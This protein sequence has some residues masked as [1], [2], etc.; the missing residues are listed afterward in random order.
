MRQMISLGQHCDVAFQLRMHGSM[1]AP[2]FFDW[3]TTPLDGLIK[4]FD[5]NFDVFY[6]DDLVLVTDRPN[7]FVADQITGV[8]FFHQFPYVSGHVTSDF[9]L[10]YQRFIRIFRFYARRFREIVTTEPVTLVRRGDITH[11]QAVNVEQSFFRC[12]PD[13]DVQFLYL[14]HGELFETDHGHAR[15]IPKTAASLGE[16]RV[17]VKLLVEEGLIEEPYRHSTAEILGAGRE[18]HSLSPHDRFSEDDL[19]DAISGNPHHPMFPLELATYYRKRAMFD[20]AETYAMR[21]MAVLDCA[22]NRFETVLSRWKGSKISANEAADALIAIVGKKADV[23]GL[24]RE[25]AASL[26]GASRYIEAIDYSARALVQDPLDETSYYTRAMAFYHQNNFAAAE[27]SIRGAI[28]MHNKSELYYH[29]HARFLDE[30][31]RLE[32]AIAAEHRALA[33]VGAGRFQSL[34][35]LGGLLARLDRHQEAIDM[36]KR[37]LPMLPSHAHTVQAW[38]DEAENAVALSQR[39]ETLYGSNT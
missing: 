16:P 4:I 28:K 18:D 15:H 2:H 30:L 23:G 10:F 27:R 24:L 35:H 6:P 13:A 11:P 17:W 20:E 1:N 9:L 5:A 22:E 21:S 36:W 29:L 31:G 34:V 7:R 33:V 32:D 14:V 8:A 12:F 19:L 37:A 3:L 39:A 26:L 25:T 38:I